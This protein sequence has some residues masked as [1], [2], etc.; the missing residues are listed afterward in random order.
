[1]IRFFLYLLV[2]G[3]VLY[4]LSTFGKKKETAFDA[5]MPTQGSKTKN[6]FKT[7]PNP[8]E[9]WFQVYETETLEDARRY[10]ARIQED[11]IECILYEQGKKDILGNELKGIGIIVPK[12]STGFAQAII[13]RMSV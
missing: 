13:S 1:M 3:G 6:R 2:F 11:D 8:N 4:F 10:Q 9:V 5:T 12:T 7:K